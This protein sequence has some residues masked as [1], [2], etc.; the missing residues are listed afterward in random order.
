MEVHMVRYLD[1]VPINFEVPA[2]VLV[3]ALLVIAA[4]TKIGQPERAIGGL[5]FLYVLYLARQRVNL[6]A[7]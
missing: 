1:N 3:C 6:G 2:A 4:L 5:I 7:I